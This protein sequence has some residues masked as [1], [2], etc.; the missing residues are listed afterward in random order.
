MSFRIAVVGAGPGGLFFA[1]IAARNLPGA[2]VVLFERNRRSD[3]FGFGVVFSDAT[4][5]RIDQADPVLRD[6]LRD[7]GRHW[8]RIDVMVGGEQHG[9]SG[10]GMAAIHRR[11]LLE[12]LQDNAERAGVELRFGAVAPPVGELS[13]NFDLVVGADGT[14]STVRAHLEEAEPIGHQ[15]TTATAKFIWFGTTH[16]FEGLSFVHRESEHGAFAVHGYP[17]SDG[18]S[19]FIVETDP[20]TWRRAGLDRFDVDQPPGASDTDSQAYLEKLFATDIEGAELV[21]NNSRWGSFKTR[22]TRTWVRGNVALLGDAVHTAHFSVGSGTKMAMEDAVSLADELVRADGDLE[23]ALDTYQ[24]VRKR[25]VARI[26]D[27]AGPSLSWWENFG[28]YQRELDPLTFSFHFFSRSIDIDRVAERD[29]GLAASVRD[30]WLAEHGTAALDT[31]VRLGEVTTTGRLLSFDATLGSLSDGEHELPSDAVTVLEAPL[32]EA[33]LDAAVAALPSSGAVLIHGGG[34]L[35]RVLL[36][37]EARLRRG[38]T[39]VIVIDA[40][41]VE[42]DRRA[43]VRSEAETLVLSRRADAVATGAGAA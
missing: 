15:V 8:E 12:L 24:D 42:G 21:T 41:R 23:A 22:R 37:E 32:D 25:S 27:A 1:T 28:R 2:E 39:S 34:E 5:R 3:A 33:D 20:G 11:T 38:L 17:I 9:F 4:L 18:L 13:A 40:T 7:H 31:P 19:T 16:L 36:S 35:T 43:G 29:P 14:N 10:N 30:A 6:A 26:Q